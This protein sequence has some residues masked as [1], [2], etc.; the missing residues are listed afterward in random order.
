[1]STSL[2]QITITLT[3]ARPFRITSG[4]WPVIAKASQDR[5]HN[6]QELTRQ[7]HLRVRRHEDGR[8]LVYGWA[9]SLY[10]GEHGTRAGFLCTLDEA[11][12][13]IRQVGDII[14]APEYLI[15]DC[16]ADLP[17]VDGDLSP[18]PAP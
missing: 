6:Q 13:V 15:T 2:D 16:T 11:P 5:D 1:M 7:Y 3:A 9:Q 18:V 17:A 14:G 10:Q 4:L 8:T 12:A